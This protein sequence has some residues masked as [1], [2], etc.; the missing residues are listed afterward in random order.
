[1]N[2]LSTCRWIS[3]LSVVLLAACQAVQSDELKSTQAA[4]VRLAAFIDE[5]LDS[6][7]VGVD[8]AIKTP[9]S[10]VAI[11][12]TQG[13]S[14]QAASEGASGV[15]ASVSLSYDAFLELDKFYSA[16]VTKTKAEGRYYLTYTDSAQQ[17]TTVS[18]LTSSVAPI[19]APLAGA[20][21]S[22]SSVAITWDPAQMPNSG[23]VDLYVKSGTVSG[24]A[25]NIY[26]FGIGNSGSFDLD[27]T[28]LSGAGTIELRHIE[29]YA[30]LPGFKQTD[31]KM[32]N[33]ATVGVTF[34][35]SATGSKSLA[36]TD[37]VDAELHACL[38][39]C[40][41]NEAVFVEVAGE[42]YSCCIE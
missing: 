34:S 25:T 33:I 36:P 23:A 9:E 31:V 37:Q 6:D 1:M 24:G 4:D 40:A 42:E 35:P 8:A 41:A 3:V 20:A 2:N 21:V 27:T 18:V 13:E 32:R 26:H 19:T 17:V 38:H 5:Y 7:T 12:L 29:T 16:S 30:S 22:G 39:I 15:S 14:L 28:N 10:D 11:E